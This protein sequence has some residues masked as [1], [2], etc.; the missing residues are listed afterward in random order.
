MKIFLIRYFLSV[1]LMFLG[2]YSPVH[3]H[4]CQDNSFSEKLPERLEVSGKKEISSLIFTSKLP[5]PDKET[6]SDGAEVDEE[7]ETENKLSHSKQKL[8]RKNY[9]TSLSGIDPTG[10]STNFRETSYCFKHFSTS[11]LNRRY[12]IFQAFRI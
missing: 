3:A 4:A 12:I 6:D 1:C 2:G 11:Q 5:S 7:E 10:I 9:F 8:D